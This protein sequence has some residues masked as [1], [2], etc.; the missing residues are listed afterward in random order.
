MNNKIQIITCRGCLRH[1]KTLN[2][3]DNTTKTLSNDNEEFIFKC[4][5]DVFP[6]LFK[7]IQEN[8]DL[9]FLKIQEIE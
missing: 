2:W 5:S 4:S 1:G 6:E 9:L 3:L 7:Y 8:N